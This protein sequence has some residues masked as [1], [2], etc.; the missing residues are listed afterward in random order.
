MLKVI[1][2]TLLVFV[3]GVALLAAAGAGYR[4]WR[5]HLNEELLAIDS[6]NGVDEAFFVDVGGS[7]QWVT[8]RGRDKANPLL[9]MVHGGP[10]VALS[11]LAA[12][13]LVYERDYTVVQWDQRGAARTLSRADGVVTGELSQEL[14]AR[15]GIGVAEDVG[16]RFGGGRKIVLL[17]FSW[18]SGVAL[19]MVRERPDLFAAYVGTSLFVNRAESLTAA[20]DAMLARA[21]GDGNQT[22]VEELVAIGRPPH[23]TPQQ[24]RTQS[25]WAALLAG[26]PPPGDAAMNRI[27]QLLVAPRYSLG[28]VV[29]YLQ[30]ALVSDEHIDLGAVDLRTRGRVFA[31]PMF[32]IQAEDD[33]LTPIGVARAYLESV[34]A[35]H[36]QLLTLRGGHNALLDNRDGFLSLLNEHVRPRALVA[37]GTL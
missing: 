30:G 34:E 33:Y 20:Y 21:R 1:G 31:L 16:A 3:V 27:A 15:D 26:L 11:P 25:K 14:L 17:G 13:L 23:T 9:L 2:K 36:T 4:A 10:G 29:S 8:V 12:A 6:P 24:A 37:A 5:Q 28:D 19:E 32:V 35:P 22:A 7:E 18:G